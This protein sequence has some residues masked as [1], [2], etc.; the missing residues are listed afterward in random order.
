MHTYMYVCTQIDIVLW[1]SNIAI[2]LENSRYLVSFAF[3]RLPDST[4]IPAPVKA[5]MGF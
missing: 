4:E 5:T 3:H 2:R 1:S